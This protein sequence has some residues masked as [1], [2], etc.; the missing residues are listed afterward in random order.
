[1][2]LLGRQLERGARGVDRLDAREQLGVEVDR[3]LML[4]QFGG[5]GLLHLV[6]HVV[7]IGLDDAEE[8][9]RYAIEHAARFLERDDRVVERGCGGVVRD[10]TD[11]D[12]IGRHRLLEARLIVAVLDDVEA[13]RLEGQRAGGG[14]RAGWRRALRRDAGE[15]RA[16]DEQESGGT[17]EHG[18]HGSPFGSFLTLA[19]MAG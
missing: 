1:M 17:Q 12:Q 5:L 18:F 16:G 6:E 11:L 13:R 19:R 14:E 2:R 15:G 8:G 3:V 7:G 9:L 4:R 10:R